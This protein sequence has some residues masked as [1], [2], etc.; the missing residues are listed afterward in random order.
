MKIRPE[1]IQAALKSTFQDFPIDPIQYLT[2]EGYV[3]D[4][5]TVRF[6]QRGKEKGLD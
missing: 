4:G 5:D 6:I 3:F 2:G 1:E